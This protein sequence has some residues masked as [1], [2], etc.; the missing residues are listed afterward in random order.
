M[1]RKLIPFYGILIV[2][3]YKLIVKLRERGKIDEFK[4][5]CN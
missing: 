3:D 5:K 2:E 1:M 4:K